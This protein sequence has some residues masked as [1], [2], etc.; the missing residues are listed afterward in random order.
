MIKTTYTTQTYELFSRQNT[1][2]AKENNMY[3]TNVNFKVTVSGS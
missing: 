1:A 3:R 2:F